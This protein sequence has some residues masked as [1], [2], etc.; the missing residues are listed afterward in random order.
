MLHSGSRALLTLVL[1]LLPAAARAALTLTTVTLDVQVQATNGTDDA[2]KVTFTVA[3]TEV[4][5]ATVTPQGA[6]GAAISLPCT[7]GTSCSLT[8]DLNQTQFNALFPTSARDYK[9]DLTQ[10]GGTD[11][12]T[13]TVSFTLPVVPSPAISEPQNGSTI[14]PGL[15]EVKF[16]AC[17]ACT[18]T[19]Q[20]V[21]TQGT[22]ELEANPNLPASSTSWMP[23][24]PLAAS[25]DFSVKVTHRTSGSLSPAPRYEPGDVP[26]SF[27][28]AATH[29][30]TVQ[31]STGFAP[32]TGDF[33]IILLDEGLTGPGTDCAVLDTPAL[34]ILDTSAIYLTVLAGIPIEYQVTLGPKGAISGPAQADL[35]GDASFET[36]APLKG[37][38]RGKDGA[39]RQRL[40]VRFVNDAL[41][42]KLRFR[43]LEEADLASLAQS[44]DL[45]SL[46]SEELRGKQDGAK[47][48]AESS[49]TPITVD[50]PIGWRLDFHLAGSEKD[51]SGATLV[52]SSGSTTS[53]AGTQSFDTAKN[54]SDIRLSSGGAEKG[55]QFRL[56]K[57][58]TDGTA[59]ITS[60]EFKFRAF[61]QSGS[62]LLP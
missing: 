60:G 26:Y 54:Q 18:A 57:L 32:P 27:T 2:F 44:P 25:S 24:T 23:Q 30:D 28:F 5:T 36:S 29:S 56:R 61:G 6:G 19:T 15:I 8:Q 37:R 3:G 46:L 4:A 59:A 13:D 42:A 40:A 14:D 48:D 11:T 39:L 16:A 35:D 45:I 50:P 53:L 43:S 51:I 7:G 41:D 12:I 1:L 20:A 62:G 47:V 31:F 22:T 34:G 38:L 55:I 21:L 10:V 58:G 52:L 9:I 33:C 17:A 49:T